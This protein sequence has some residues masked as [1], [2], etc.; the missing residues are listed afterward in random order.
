MCLIT[1]EQNFDYCCGAV[2]VK[3]AKENK[4]EK[5]SEN[6]MIEDNRSVLVG[7][8][9]KSNAGGALKVSINSDAFSDCSTYVTSDGQTYVPL[10]VSL[11]ALSK[12]LQGERAVTTI[13]QMQD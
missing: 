2:G 10:V 4:I 3:M 5:N 11:N 1:F 12:V 13:S 7:Y 6:E 8:V 9:R